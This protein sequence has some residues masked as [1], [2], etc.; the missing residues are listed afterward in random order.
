MKRIFLGTPQLAAEIFEYLLKNNISF[1][2]LITSPD[3]P[4]GRK[5]IITPPPTK[6]VALKYGIKVFQPKNKDELDNVIGCINPDY[7]FVVAYGI[8]IK[9]ETLN[10]AKIGFFNLHFSLLPAY[11]GADPIR[12]AILNG[13]EETGITV[14]KIDEGIDTGLILL[15]EKIKINNNE[16]AKE[17]ITKLTILGKDAMYKAV[18]IIE[19][20]DMILIEQKGVPSYAPKISLKDTFVDFYLPWINVYN[21]I[22]AFSYEP[23]AR[24][25]FKHKKGEI[26]IQ[27]L[28]A[29]GIN[30]DYI[31]FSP[32]QICGFENKK[33]I[34]VKC[35]KG[36]ICIL[37]IKPEG[38]KEMSAY[39]YF[40]NGMKLKVGDYLI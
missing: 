30:N 35:L 37:K 3:K 29:V 38:K 22:R 26:Q 23:Y 16:T 1:D 33:G 6:I 7:A 5:Q 13:E 39:E 25:I 27:I 24:F 40:V 4:V 17:L 15:Q 28:S 21:K 14:F 36:S 9:K 20:G 19:S 12:W 32:G 10:K 11:R 31:D 2:A 34:L 8:I 18:K